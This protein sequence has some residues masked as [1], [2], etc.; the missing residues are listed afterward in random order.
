[1]FTC[2]SVKQPIVVLS[3]CKAE[4]VAANTAICHA[5]RL[6]NLLKYLE[7]PQETP[8]WILD[9]K[10]SSIA[11]VKN[12]VYHEKRKHIDTRYHFI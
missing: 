5:I 10:K 11:P 3:T 4:H 6:K 2:S 1:M 7:F 12:H 9:Y 8:T